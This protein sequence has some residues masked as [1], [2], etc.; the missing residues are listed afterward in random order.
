MLD[1]TIK[2]EL[3]ATL[4]E[5]CERSSCWQENIEFTTA[6]GVKDYYLLPL[7]RGLVHRLMWVTPAD[8]PDLVVSARLRETGIVS[9]LDP[10]TSPVQMVATVA[11]TVDDPTDQHGFPE[12]DASLIKRHHNGI[13]DGLLSRLMSQ[14]SKPYSSEKGAIYHGRRF[15]GAINLAKRDAR[16]GNKFAGAS[17]R[18]PKMV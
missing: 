2:F 10:P 17:W 14:L 3:F 6:P 12:F 15:T 5:F 13:V 9:L 16:V 7:S 8:Q 1:G 11:L 4:K 18:F